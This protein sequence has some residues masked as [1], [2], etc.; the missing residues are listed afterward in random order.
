MSSSQRSATLESLTAKRKQIMERLAT[1]PEFA[2]FSPVGPYTPGEAIEQ[3]KA[4]MERCQDLTEDHAMLLCDE[5]RGLFLIMNHFCQ[6]DK[7]IT[8]EQLEEGRKLVGEAQKVIEPLKSNEKCG[9]QVAQ[10]CNSM[11][12]REHFLGLLIEDSL[13]Q[14]NDELVA[15]LDLN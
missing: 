8:L 12:R 6:L 5:T 1:D 15:L 14:L 13:D 2:P 9:T 7:E 11:R 4:A 10:W 3:T